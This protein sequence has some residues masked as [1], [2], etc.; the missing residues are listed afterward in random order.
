MK[1]RAKDLRRGIIRKIESLD[2]FETV[3]NRK[4]SATDGPYNTK[5]TFVRHRNW[6]DTKKKFSAAYSQRQQNVSSQLLTN[7]PDSH[8]TLQLSSTLIVVL[9][10]TIIHTHNIRLAAGFQQH[11]FSP[12]RGFLAP[13]SELHDAASRALH[14]YVPHLQ[15]LSS[16]RMEVGSSSH[17]PWSLMLAW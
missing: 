8:F 6:K 12:L 15:A 14:S 2:G 10:L 5:P 7:N 3:Y 4:P 16:S 17:C 11:R 9:N 1:R 13:H